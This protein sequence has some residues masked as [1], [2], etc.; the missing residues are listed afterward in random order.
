LKVIFENR[1]CDEFSVDRMLTKEELKKIMA[2]KPLSVAIP[3]E[4]GGRGIV[5]KECLAMLSAAS[6]ESIALSLTF[7]INIALFL[8]PVAK[9]AQES[10]KE[11]IFKNFLEQQQIGGLMITEPDY[12]SDAL[13]MQTWNKKIGDSYKVE[14][15]KHW[16]GLTGMADYW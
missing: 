5:V 6:Y 13:N 12:G 10:I 1:F 14:G 7:G 4:Y 2:E 11:N 15:M 3:T 8:E 16:Q 9:Y